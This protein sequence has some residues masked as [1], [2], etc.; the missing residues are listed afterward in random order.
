M[1]GRAKE[2]WDSACPNTF[3]TGSACDATLCG[4]KVTLPTGPAVSRPLNINGTDYDLHDANQPI[5]VNAAALLNAICSVGAGDPFMAAG[6]SIAMQNAQIESFI[7]NSG[8][9]RSGGQVTSIVPGPSLSVGGAYERGSDT[10][11][12]LI[13]VNYAKNLSDK[14][15]FNL[16]GNFLYGSR[17]KL[18]QYGFNLSPALGMEI[19]KPTATYAVGGFI[20]IAWSKASLA[21]TDA[22]FSAYAVGAGGIGTATTMLGNTQLSG[23]ASVSA[24]K[25]GGTLASPLTIVAHAVHPLSTAIDGFA[26]ASYGNDLAGSG[27]GFFSLGAGAAFGKSQLGLRGF[28][29]SGYT[30]VMLGFVWRTELEGSHALQKPPE[31]PPKEEPAKK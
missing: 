23:G 30:A 15:F 10:N 16:Q 26:T 5:D 29:G 31:E 18:S 22:S 3:T 2:Q 1:S 9:L 17:T 19:R 21:D 24:R 8:F 7:A 12:F 28:F 14:H 20:P 6:G 25:T 4:T 11:A 13:P 27:A